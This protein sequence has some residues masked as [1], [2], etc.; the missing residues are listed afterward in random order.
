MIYQGL[1]AVNM[2]KNSGKLCRFEP[3]NL[4]WVEEFSQ[5]AKML[6]DAGWYSF[7]RVGGY[8]VEVTKSFAKNYTGSS[9]NFQ[10]LSFELNEGLIA[11]ATWLPVEGERWFKKHMFEVD[12]SLYLLPG[13]E[14]LD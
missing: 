10:T 13:Y 3:V 7:E 14:D 6:I 1:I 2:K 12:L 9:I 11:E 8:N 5:C 4:K